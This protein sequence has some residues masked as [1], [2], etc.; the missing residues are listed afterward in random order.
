MLTFAV[1]ETVKT[2]SVT[3]R[4]DTK[5]EGD[6]TFSV[7][8]GALSENL[9]RGTSTATMTITNDDAVPTYRV[10]TGTTK[11]QTLTGTDGADRISGGGG[12]DTLRGGAGH[13]ILVASSGN[14]VLDGGAGEDDMTGGAGND[15]Y[16]VDSIGDVVVE[17]ST[18]GTDTIRTSLARYTLGAWIEGLVYTGMASFTG[19]GNSLA[20]SM[21]G[22][23]GNDTLYG[24]SGNDTLNGGAGANT[25]YGDAGDDRLVGG[26]L[27]DVLDGGTGNDAMSGGA[28]D[29]TYFVDSAKDVITEAVNGGVDTVR[30]TASSYTLSAYVDNLL[31]VGTGAFKGIGSADANG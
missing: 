31:Y 25:L 10:I 28:G 30:V 26:A 29:D 14:D 11:A 24:G 18:G 9:W 19:I 23:I 8:L 27:G 21:T 20:N 13:D 5:Y 22:G 7:V 4:G 3:L 15:T 17:A 16:H 6:E 12:N 2:I 1:G